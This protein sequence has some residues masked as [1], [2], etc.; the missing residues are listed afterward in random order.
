MSDFLELI[1][2]LAL[3]VIGALA[4]AWLGNFSWPDTPISRI[5]WG[6]ILILLG[7]LIWWE[8]R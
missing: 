5:L 1:L 2:D 6:V 7:V 4:E 3:N 8:L